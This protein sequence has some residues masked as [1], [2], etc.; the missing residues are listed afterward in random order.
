MWKNENEEWMPMSRIN[1]NRAWS[2]FYIV[3]VALLI[4]S[5]SFPYIVLIGIDLLTRLN[6]ILGWLRISNSSDD[7]IFTEL[8]M[9]NYNC[10]NRWS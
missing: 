8:S 3:I 1:Y 7:D 2:A 4:S 10:E 9:I 5:F 6:F